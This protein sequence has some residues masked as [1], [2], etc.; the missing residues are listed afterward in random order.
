[1]ASADTAYEDTK[2]WVLAPP[3]LVEPKYRTTQYE[4]GIKDRTFC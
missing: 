3:R 4:H 2:T 1:M